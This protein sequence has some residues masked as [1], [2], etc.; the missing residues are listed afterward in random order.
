MVPEL[1]NAIR[2][3]AHTTGKQLIADIVIHGDLELTRL[4]PVRNRHPAM[5]RDLD[6]RLPALPLVIDR[7]E[8]DF[9][10]PSTTPIVA[11]TKPILTRSEILEKACRAD[12]THDMQRVSRVVIDAIGPSG[13]G[14]DEETDHQE[15]SDASFHYL[16]PHERYYMTEPISPGCAAMA[17][18]RY[19]PVRELELQN[20][21]HN[22]L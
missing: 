12:L 4:A 21:Q 9:G 11:R 10:I 16:N 3:L 1:Q 15:P 19:E 18:R 22:I 5:C 14:T 6:G 7:P 8:R 13:L 20:I 2:G 17:K